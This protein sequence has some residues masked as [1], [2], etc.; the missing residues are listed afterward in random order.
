MDIDG[1]KKSDNSD[2]ASGL[3]PNTYREQLE[4]KFLLDIDI[5]G[6]NAR[7]GS[8]KEQRAVTQILHE[9]LMDPARQN[10]NA[11]ER[12]KSFRRVA[13]PRGPRGG[14]YYLSGRGKEANILGFIALLES[15]LS[16]YNRELGIKLPLSLRLFLGAGDFDMTGERPVGPLAEEARRIICESGVEDF[17]RYSGLDLLVILNEDFYRNFKESLDKL[18]ENSSFAY[19]KK[20]EFKSTSLKT[21]DSASGSR[22]IYIPVNLSVA[23]TGDDQKQ[24]RGLT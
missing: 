4:D 8:Q 6:Y 3:N 12:E 23:E 22:V 15:E 20:I 19:L 24:A 7:Y 18:P 13:K 5:V 16:E 1:Q 2:E 17:Q 9:L 11:E 21:S 14:M 10:F